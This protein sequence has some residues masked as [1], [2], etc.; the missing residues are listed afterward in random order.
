MIVDLSSIYSS[1]KISSVEWMCTFEV[2]VSVREN[3]YHDE[4][5][6]LID[7]ISIFPDNRIRNQ[8][9]NDSVCS[10]IG[11]VFAQFL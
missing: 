2:K 5:V 11:W 7:I 9:R 6:V 10:L 8:N 3:F 4:M 1:G